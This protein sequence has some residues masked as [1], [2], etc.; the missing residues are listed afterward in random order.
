ML[1]AAI[2]LDELPASLTFAN[3]KVKNLG[4][5]ALGDEDVGGL[6]V[7]VNDAFRVRG[8]ERVRDLDSQREQHFQI[9]WPAPDSVLQRQA[10]E[11]FHGDESFAVL[12]VNLV[13]GADVRMVQGRG[14]FGF[15]LKAAQ[16]LRIFGNVV[17][18][19]LEGDKAAQLHVFRLVDN[20]H[21]PTT[22]LLDDPV[23][24]NSLADHGVAPY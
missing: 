14:S 22:E 24:R 17:G 7:A 9:Q 1:R 19:E 3:P 16:G 13:N 20:A 18:Q 15:A 11:E 2:W 5:S 6:D 21:A 10:V 12:V 4:V 8:V 23:V